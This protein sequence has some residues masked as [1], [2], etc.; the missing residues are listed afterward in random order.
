MI[1][2]LNWQDFY[3]RIIL[4]RHKAFDIWLSPQHC[5]FGPRPPAAFTH[6]KRKF[7]SVSKNNQTLLNI[8]NKVTKQWNWIKLY[9]SIQRAKSKLSKQSLS[10]LSAKIIQC[11]FSTVVNLLLDKQSIHSTVARIHGVLVLNTSSS[12]AARACKADMYW[13][14]CPQQGQWQG[15]ENIAQPPVCQHCAS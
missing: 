9:R 12:R 6:L 3:F 11:L 10:Y 1:I 7:F 14:V 5:E 13:L 4:F 8:F 2:F 15:G